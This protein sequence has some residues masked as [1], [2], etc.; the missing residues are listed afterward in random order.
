MCVL[1]IKVPIRKNSG[2]LLKAPRMSLMKKTFHTIN[3]YFQCSWSKTCSLFT[4]EWLYTYYVISLFT[5]FISNDL[6]FY[7]I[8]KNTEDYYNALWGCHGNM[9]MNSNCYKTLK[10]WKCLRVYRWPYL[11]NEFKDLY[12]KQNIV[13]NKLG[14][15]FGWLA[16]FYGL[17]TLVGYLKQNPTNT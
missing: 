9:I 6:E 17:L 16:W 5:S 4:V 13:C 1:S 12:V 7:N 15:L 14:M 3:I 8:R 10:S 2:N 11:S